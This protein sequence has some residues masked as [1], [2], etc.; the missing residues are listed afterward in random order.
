MIQTLNIKLSNG[1]S[2]SGWQ[3][4]IEIDAG[5]TLEDLHFAIQKAVKFDN[6]HMFEFILGRTVRNRSA[7]R[8]DDENGLIYSQ[9]IGELFPLPDK[10]SLYYHFDFGD[11]WYFKVVKSRKANHEPQKGVKYPRLVQETG[12][13][14]EQ[15]PD[16]DE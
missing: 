12:E 11:D 16:D 1:D 14:P 3:G 7:V 4:E 10:M 6:D 5:D 13:R 2:E 8:F 15:Y 9:T